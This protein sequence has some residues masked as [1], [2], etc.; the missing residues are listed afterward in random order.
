MPSTFARRAAW[1]LVAIEFAALTAWA[2][3]SAGLEGLGAFFTTLGPI[4]I[5]VIVDLLLAL[6]VGVILIERD[7]KRRGTSS[8]P[9]VL[10]TLGTGSLGLLAYLAR[11]DERDPGR[12]RPGASAA[13][14]PANAE[15]RSV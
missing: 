3:V 10:L 6:L 12:D 11:H 8:L 1:S 4:G 14:Q 7:A 9:F 5:L 13:G 15:A 2:L